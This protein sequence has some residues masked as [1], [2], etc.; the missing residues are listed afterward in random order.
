MKRK[1]PIGKIDDRFNAPEIVSDP[2]HAAVIPSLVVFQACAKDSSP[3]KQSIPAACR[4][5]IG[6]AA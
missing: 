5:Q 2:L 1:M 3:S 4:E 6:P